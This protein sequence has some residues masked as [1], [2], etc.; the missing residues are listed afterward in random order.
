MVLQMFI[1]VQESMCWCT[2][3]CC[4]LRR[5]VVRV[6]RTENISLFPKQSVAKCQSPI[7]PRPKVTS[8]HKPIVLNYSFASSPPPPKKGARV[9]VVSMYFHKKTYRHLKLLK[10]ENGNLHTVVSVGMVSK[11]MNDI[12]TNAE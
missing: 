4:L 3:D 5:Q 8:N 1:S 12:R 10:G 9:L 7:S 6:S 11:G 2:A